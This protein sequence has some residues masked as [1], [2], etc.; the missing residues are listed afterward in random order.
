[1]A[2]SGASVFISYRRQGGADVAR[3]LQLFLEQNGFAV[4]LDVDSLDAGHFNSQLLIQI[5]R[6]EH[7]LL[8]CSPCCLDRCADERDFVRQEIAHA[9]RCGRKFVPVTLE[10][11]R[12]PGRD[13]LPADI[14]DVTSHHAFEYSHTH[15]TLTKG[16]LLEM[17]GV[18]SNA[19]QSHFA[20]SGSD[21]KLEAPTGSRSRAKSRVDADQDR[22]SVHAEDAPNAGMRGASSRDDAQADTEAP[23]T[24]ADDASKVPAEA[25]ADRA[26]R[27]RGAKDRAQATRRTKSSVQSTSKTPSAANFA[28]LL[29]LISAVCW[30][31]VLSKPSEPESLKRYV[32]A[33]SILSASSLVFSAV[34]L[35]RAKANGSRGY[36]RSIVA[37]GLSI[38]G[39]ALRYALV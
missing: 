37:A 35:G 33:G 22:K 23:G 11:F 8:V 5:E 30:I 19:P 34:G 16:R 31:I 13:S 12:W 26:R 1:M 32:E 15:W 20:S 14:A 7:F 3:V 28:V 18:R 36:L 39:L 38:A 6:S 4:F 10:G 29:S 21:A 9:L 2:G 24:D 17:L 25:A 27:K